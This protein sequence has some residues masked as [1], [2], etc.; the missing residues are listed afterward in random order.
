MRERYS[1]ER[2]SMRLHRS[3]RDS[4]SM[5]DLRAL[6]ER[7]GDEVPSTMQPHFPFVVPELSFLKFGI[8]AVLTVTSAKIY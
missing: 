7:V 8:V 5:R 3:A 4:P 6:L 1:C 2:E